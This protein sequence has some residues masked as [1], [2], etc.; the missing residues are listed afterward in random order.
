MKHLQ[1]ITLL[2][3]IAYQ[4]MAQSSIKGKVQVAKG[5]PLTN[6]IVIVK[7]KSNQ[8]DIIIGNTLTD[9]EGN[10]EININNSATSLTL[11][12]SHPNIKPFTK[13]IKNV[14]QTIDILAEEGTIKLKEVIVKPKA[15]NAIGDTL[16]Y[17]L[18]YF[19]EKN[20]HKLRETLEHLPG[21]SV[22]NSGKV[23]YNGREIT[24]FQ[25][26]G[27]DLF[28][29][30]YPIALDRIDP[31]DVIAVDIMQ[32]HQPI[33]A[34]KGSRITD[35]VALNLKLSPNAKNTIIGSTT[36]GGGYRNGDGLY[37][38]Q[39]DGGMFNAK[40]QVYATATIDNIDNDLTDTYGA[41]LV[42]LHDHILSSSMPQTSM[43]SNEDEA[44]TSGRAISLNGLYNLSS[45][46]KWSYA[47]SAMEEHSD[48]DESNTTT[49]YLDNE[50]KKHERALHLD[51]RYRNADF[52]LKCEENKRR[53]Y[54]LNKLTGEWI[55]DKPDVNCSTPSA[56]LN[57]DI[58]QRDYTLNNQFRLIRR[59]NDV[60]GLDTRINLQF[61]NSHEYLLLTQHS[62]GNEREWSENSQKV[63]QHF[64]LAE[65]RQEMLSTIKLYGFTIDPYWFAMSD[66]NRLITSLSS[67]D[68]FLTT[69][70]IITEDDLR[71][72]RVNIG[73]GVTFMSDV[74]GFRIC[75]YIP[76][77]YSHISVHS[78][79]DDRHKSN[80][81]VLPN[82]SIEHPLLSFFS[83]QVGWS[84]EMQ[85]NKPEDFLRSYILCNSYELAQH[86]ISEITTTDYQHFTAKLK[87]ANA[88]NM[89]IGNLQ[90]LYDWFECPMMV[91]EQVE[92]NQVTLDVT[93]Q[94]YLTHSLNVGGELSKS[95]YWK[96]ALLGLKAYYTRY[97]TAQMFNGTYTPFVLYGQSLSLN[98]GLSPFK[99]LRTELNASF[100]RSRTPSQ[101]PGLSDIVVKR[102][103]VK[104]KITASAKYWSLSCNTLYTQQDCAHAF[105]ANVKVYYTTKNSEWSFC[106]RNLLN[107]RQININSVSAQQEQQAIF[108]L[109]ARSAIL[110]VKFKL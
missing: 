80:L 104:G 50:E 4:S 61:T 68:L 107:A 49:Y 87:Y 6:A 75:G 55:N 99:E 58:L 59:W 101:E 3:L 64:Y 29:G 97:S 2:L 9:D 31:K 51:E 82:V 93:S 30:K 19:K 62:K 98:C 81:Y 74:N 37:T 89:L 72:N 106:V 38:A 1:M 73:G 8:H 14:S 102:V 71:Y 36:I 5:H 41:P 12:V 45:T 35:D 10:Y 52:F 92:D 91:N 16:T 109:V 25:I 60:N 54:F 7:V 32:H 34:L 84:R 17:N 56:L 65:F 95:F 39:I 33:R 67:P 70:S 27:G 83:M 47:L 90:L 77:V 110:S 15:I 66:W 88:F 26:E 43:L 28:E 44:T 13:Q 42:N 24:E 63:R 21:I 108:C 20:D 69:D 18:D 40:Q 79:Y 46:S 96:K 94:S 11:C 105:L 78:I 53:N 22:T 86:R 100:N 23:T 76:L 57:E 85:D 48:K 103:M